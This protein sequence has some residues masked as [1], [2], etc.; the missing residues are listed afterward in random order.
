M[1][2]LHHAL[3]LRAIDLGNVGA[4]KRAAENLGARRRDKI[5]MIEIGALGGTCTHTLPADN[6]LL[7]SSATRAKWWEVLVTLQ[8]SLPILFCDT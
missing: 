2:L 3:K 1:L 8:S 4:E 7:F 5:D 6:G